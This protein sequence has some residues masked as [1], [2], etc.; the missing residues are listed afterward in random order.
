V[1]LIPGRPAVS[2]A[3]HE[4]I[5]AA[6]VA[7]DPVAAEAAMRDHITSVIEALSGLAGQQAG[8]GGSPRSM[9]R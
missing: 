8:T 4:Q 6:V 5:V 7:R 1:S 3:Q 2:L 9:A